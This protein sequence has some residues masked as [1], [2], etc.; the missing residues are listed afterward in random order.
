MTQK[1]ILVL[2]GSPRKK[3]NSAVLAAR[4]AEGAE[5][6]GAEVETLYLAGMDIN[7]CI[8]CEDCHREGADGC[9]V[10]DDMQAVYVKLADADSIVFA[11][12]VY[13]FSV[14][15][16]MKTAIDRIYAVGVGD[17]NILKGKGMGVILT[18]ADSDPYTSGAVNALRMFQ[19][20]SGYLGTRI[21]GTVYG[22]AYEA[23]EIEGNRPVMEE[24]YELGG[25]LAAYG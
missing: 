14:S 4:L 21:V 16:Q 6:G 17:A 11:S 5:A 9:I 24:A 8:A 2:M 23:G 19:D 22:T 13:W 3:G 12:P 1:K 20:I 25:K 18:Y 15:A 7:P 10:K